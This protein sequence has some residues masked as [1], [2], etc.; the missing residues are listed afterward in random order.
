MQLGQSST[1]RVGIGVENGVRGSAL[2]VGVAAVFVDRDLDVQ[3]LVDDHEAMPKIRGRVR[4]AD[5]GEFW[6]KRF[7]WFLE[8]RD[9][10]GFPRL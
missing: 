10:E 6:C 4:K 2:A 3:F 1:N 9:S 8:R 5:H 7:R